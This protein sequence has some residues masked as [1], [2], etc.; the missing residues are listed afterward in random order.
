VHERPPVKTTCPYCGVGCGVLAKVE[1]GGTVM[2]AGDPDHPAN[3]GRLCSK[4]SALAE[5]LSL[6]DRLLHPEVY[7]ERANW[8]GALD[9]V[10][11]RFKDAIAEHGPDSVAFYVSGQCLTED[12]YV[13]NKLMKGFI[14]SANIDTNSRLCMASS[15]AGHRRAFGSDTVPGVYEDLEEADLVVLVGSNLAWCHPILFQRLMAARE[16][17]P[18]AIVAIDPRRTPTAASADLHLAVAPDGDVALFTGLLR[19]LAQNGAVDRD[20]LKEHTSGFLEALAAAD[21]M[22]VK[23][24]AKATGL[25]ANEIVHFFTLFAS[26]QRVVTVYSQGVNQSASGTDKVNAIVNCHLATGRIGRP[27]MGP[28]SIT[29]QPNAMGGREVGGL[30]NQLAAHMA[31]EDADARDRVKRFWNAPT[32]ADRPGLKAVDLFRAVGDGRVKALWIIA[33]NPIDSL[34]DADAVKIALAACPFVVVSDVVRETDTNRFAHVLLPAAAWGEKDGTVTNSERCI[35]RQ[36]AFLPT[37]GEAQ[38]DWWML[39]EVARRMGFVNAFPYDG[40]API[41]AEHAALSTF[42]NEGTRDFDLGA[43]ADLDKDAFDA[44]APIQWPVPR[45][46]ASGGR[47]FG[48]GRFYTA[49]RRARFVATPP[50]APEPIDPAF[51]LI[52]NTGRIRD[53]WHTMTRSGKSARLSGHIAE[54]YAEIHPTDAAERGIGAASLVSIVSPHGSVVLRARLS[55]EQRRGSVFAPFHWNDQFAAKARV[56]ALVSG[57][58]DPISGQP[59]SKSARVEVKSF[60]VNWYGFALCVQKP[61]VAE[62]AY[63]ALARIDGGWRMELAGTS[64]PNDWTVFAEALVGV[65]DG[66]TLAYHDIAGGR[67]RF[68]IFA[69]GRLVG[70]LFVAPEPVEV[71]RGFAIQH[72][73]KAFTEPR[74][75]LELLSGR[76]G[77]DRPDAGAIVC[78]CFN[79]GV[80]QIVAAIRGG[81]ATV[82]AV[83]GA[84]RAG[85]NCGSCRP[86]I[87]KAIDEQIAREADLGSGHIDHSQNRLAESLT[88]HASRRAGGELLR[89]GRSPE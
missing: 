33:T 47:F 83:G 82:E 3:F 61:D 48:D 50:P 5:T 20:F 87:R 25:A 80:N 52:L 69:D 79:V 15:V 19:H 38:P 30:A 68:A 12:Y 43:L 77:S 41:F 22:T 57:Q 14:G 56:D 75:R 46:K 55:P 85:T 71:A 23:A 1:A 84:T 32:I 49:D 17:R 86:E 31:I 26:T 36:R 35:S 78:S 73:G 64:A 21:E 11:K 4:G 72:F 27:G 40:A 51:P 37:P 28:F 58:T 7:G 59:A 54:P 42:E 34:P 89:I 81:A 13:A 76:P 10:A 44:M 9:L 24:V 29:G 65:K 16:K 39:A 63:W 74:R 2:V 6:E 8:D 67:H 53:Q 88:P 60:A 18:I 45:G 62:A 66:E 70:A